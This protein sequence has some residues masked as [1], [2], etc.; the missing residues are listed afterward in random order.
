MWRRLAKIERSLMECGG[1]VR[2]IQNEGYDSA[3]CLGFAI[4]DLAEVRIRFAQARPI[5]PIK[6]EA[7]SNQKGRGNQ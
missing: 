3:T 4:C 2:R 1:C 6:A 7:R 5:L